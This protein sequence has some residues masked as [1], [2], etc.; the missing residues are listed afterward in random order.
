MKSEHTNLVKARFYS[1]VFAI[2]AATLLFVAYAFWPG[3]FSRSPDVVAAQSVQSVAPKITADAV[4][5][6]KPILVGTPTRIVVPRL[7][8]DLPVIEGAYNPDDQ[9]WT[10][11]DGRFEAYFALPSS[12]ANDHSGNTFIY[13]HNNRF[14]FGALENLV[15]GDIVKVYTDNQ[16]EFTY[17][18][19][20]GKELKPNETSIFDYEGPPQLT[21]QTCVGNWYEL[22]NLHTFTL[23]SVA[24]RGI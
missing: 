17:S 4:E 1:S 3:I 2:Y 21:L 6:S 14:V 22:R 15:V 7:A 12:P 24:K 11:V 5:P 23:E 16:L 10:L 20:S 8:I 9:S 19:V 18:Y 13:G